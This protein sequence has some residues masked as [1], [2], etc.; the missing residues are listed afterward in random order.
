MVLNIA[1]AD[2]PSAFLTDSLVAL[3][4]DGNYFAPEV[5]WDCEIQQ[6]EFNR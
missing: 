2:M 4:E 5:L 1:K 6:L 3:V